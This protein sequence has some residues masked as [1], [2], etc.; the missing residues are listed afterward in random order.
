MLWNRGAARASL[1]GHERT[2]NP[3]PAAASLLGKNV[4]RRGSQALKRTRQ[5]R[6]AH[7][8]N[9]IPALLALAGGD[10]V[11]KLKAAISGLFHFN[12]KDAD[13]KANAV[14]A[15]ERAK[16]GDV[17]GYSEIIQLKANSATDTGKKAYQAAY[18]QLQQEGAINAAGQFVPVLL[19]GHQVAGATPTTT[20]GSVLGAVAPVAVAVAKASKPRR[21]RYPAYQD[22]YGRQRYSYKQPGESFRLPAGATPLPGAPYSFFRGAVGGGGAASTVGQ[23]AVAGAAGAGAYLVTQKLL[24]YLGGRAQTAEEAGVNAARAHR[25]ALLA[26]PDQK[27]AINAA[28]FAKLAELGYD[29]TTFQRTRSGLDTF[30]ETYNPFGG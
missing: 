29:P 7:K 28:Y 5:S 3:S 11:G 18:D 24:Q 1:M 22:R 14:K 27:A 10:P 6:P 25:E 8:A 13:R 30:L 26:H 20:L 17:A 4:V 2:H 15:Y 21:A 12:A 19:R 16:N 23:L 9:P